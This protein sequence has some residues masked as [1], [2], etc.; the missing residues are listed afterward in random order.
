MRIN[1]IN[2]LFTFFAA[3]CILICAGF[4]SDAF[5]QTSYQI[6]PGVRVGRINARSSEAELKKIYGRK[7]VRSS[8]I[9]LGEGE[10]EPG[11]VIFPNNPLKRIEILWKDA[12]RKRSPKL[13]QLT[14]E[15]SVW[16]TPQGIT[17]G[18]R[19][20]DLERLN[21]RPFLLAGFGW[22]YEGT[23]ISWENG[24]LAKVFGKENR[25][26]LLRLSDRTGSRV[27]EKEMDSVR[28][29]GNFPS[30]NRV[31]RKINPKVYQIIVEFP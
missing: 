17:L 5:A 31:M 23:V 24:K 9:S 4:L 13:V 20:K 6:V 26:G 30:D 3:F 29:D 22:D 12:R 8:R 10:Y 25:L 2:K 16:Q 27:S 11:T 7:N 18:T 28:G 15:K 1:I 14:G 19:L 21:G